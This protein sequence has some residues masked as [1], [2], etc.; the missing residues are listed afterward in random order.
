MRHNAAFTGIFH[1]LTGRPEVVS[2][3]TASKTAAIM[4]IMKKTRL[5]TLIALVVLLSQ[6]GVTLPVQ[7]GTSTGDGGY[8]DLPICLPGLY[9]ST[10]A[11]CVPLGSSQS[12]K[13]LSELG[14]PYP[15]RDLP[16]ASPDP[17]LS[18]LPEYLARITSNGEVPVYASLEAATSDGTIIN[19]IPG[20][21]SRYVTMYSSREVNGRTFVQTEGGGWVEATPFYSWP[22]SQGLEF[23]ATPKNDF[24]WTIVET[25]SYS[26]PSFSAPTVA[27]YAKYDVIQIYQTRAAEGYDWF[28]IGPQEWVPAVKARVVVVDTQKP[29]G[30]EKDR[31]INI[32]LYNQ[33]MAVY[34]KGRLIFAALIATG[35]GEL[36][37]D[38][39][40]YQVYE[41]FET[42][43]MQGSYKSDRSDFYFLQSV[44]W[45]LYYNN[46]QA[47]HG[48]YWPTTLGFKQ[49]HGCV[50]MF[51]GDA[52]WVYNWA[53]VGDYV[54]VHDP[55]G[56]TPMP[57]PTPAPTATPAMTPT[58]SANQP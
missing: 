29:A 9:Q 35:S 23:S 14:F 16:A 41:K 7:A 8:Y 48:I 37:S 55:S 57:T 39:G 51:P 4:E 11:T 1:L 56:Q 19:T 49:S 58:P 10:P 2:R 34:E 3:K 18:E 22:R 53:D 33:T 44:P 15:I 36:Y 13:A 52:H 38:P 28:E 24:G 32:D 27:Q 26:S 42:H 30:V 17:S 47:I 45:S 43:T 5:F 25:P 12:I 54:Y 20:G 6:G 46:A 40:V 21:G 50:N 31:W